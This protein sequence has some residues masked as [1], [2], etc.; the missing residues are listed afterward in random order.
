MSIQIPNIAVML[1]I[2]P[3]WCKLIASDKKT[4]EVRKTRPK[5]EPPFKSYIYCTKDGTSVYGDNNC[6]VTDVLGLLS[7]KAKQSFEDISKL[8]EWNGKV[9][10]EFIC[11]KIIEYE[12]FKEDFNAGI[13]EGY[14]ITDCTELSLNDCLEEKEL[15]KYGKGKPLYGWHISD[16]IIY[17]EP[18]E[19]SRFIKDRCAFFDNDCTCH[20]TCCYQYRETTCYGQTV[21]TCADPEMC[22]KRVSHPPQSWCYVEV[23]K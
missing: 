22:I 6:Y 11:D 14:A 1:S 20:E 8:H 2:K 4:I 13:Y 15:V 5:I 7:P 12:Y 3:K 18:K 23:L 21:I 16:L 10:G 9:I 17:N 19:L